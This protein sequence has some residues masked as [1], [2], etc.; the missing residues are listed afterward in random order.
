[1]EIIKNR[2]G[3]E[4]SIEW[5]ASNKIRVMG[6]SQ[7]I[8]TSPGKNGG[9]GMFDFEG[10]PAYTV[11]G[12]IFFDKLNWKIKNIEKKDTKYKDLYECILEVTPIYPN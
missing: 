12:K 6:E 10:G 8:R 9:V 5:I 11:G 2:Y 4:R 3:I 1:M 7:F